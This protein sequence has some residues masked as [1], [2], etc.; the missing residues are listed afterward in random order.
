VRRTIALVHASLVALLVLLIATSAWAA[1]T[2]V[3]VSK[4]D[5]LHTAFRDACDDHGFSA[6]IDER[7]VR[8]LTSYF[9]ADGTL[10]RQEISGPQVSIFQNDNSDGAPTIEIETKGSTIL[11]PNGDG[12]TTMV[13]KGSGYAYD[14]GTHTGEPNLVWFTGK[15]VSVGRWDETTQQFDVITQRI[16][17]IS[18]D[19][20]EMLL[21][22]IKTRH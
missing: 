6:R 9:S 7:E 20:C 14:P 12:T 15:V 19:I 11:T 16:Q 4:L 18:S 5:P 13:Q 21:T 1:K 22:G 17:G 8:T 2:T 3:V 10:L